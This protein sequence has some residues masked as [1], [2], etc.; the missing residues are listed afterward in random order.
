MGFGVKSG[1]DT[2]FH[3]ARDALVK[4]DH[5][6]TYIGVYVDAYNALKKAIRHHC[7]VLR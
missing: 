7:R 3:D 1:L 2:I 6:L 4:P 5:K